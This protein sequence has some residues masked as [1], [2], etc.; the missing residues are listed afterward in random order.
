MCCR[1]LPGARAHTPVQE[2]REE[3]KKGERG[4]FVVAHAPITGR[5]WNT[6]SGKPCQTTATAVFLAKAASP[7]ECGEMGRRRRR[8][9]GGG[10]D[11]QHTWFF[12]QLRWLKPSLSSL[13]NHSSLLSRLPPP[14]G[15]ALSPLPPTTSVQREMGG[16]GGGCGHPRCCCCCCC[17]A[18]RGARA[19]PGWRRLWSDVVV[20]FAR[21]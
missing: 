18:P 8:K 16:G 4:R 13:P 21:G 19:K 9:E 15:T 11:T 10:G 1:C 20:V 17:L 2:G 7:T 3:G 14:S 12:I 6:S 5:P